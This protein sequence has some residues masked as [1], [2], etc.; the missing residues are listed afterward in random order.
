M[1]APEIENNGRRIHVKIPFRLWCRSITDILT[2]NIWLQTESIRRICILLWHV[3]IQQLDQCV[4]FIMWG[5]HSYKVATKFL[6]I[7]NSTLFRKWIL[8]KWLSKC[9][10]QISS[11]LLLCQNLATATPDLHFPRPAH[12]RLK[13]THSSQF[14]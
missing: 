9:K 1:V 7:F 6:Y 3:A 5:N 4:T 2:F 10:P 12:I 13:I 8:A 14:I 11:F